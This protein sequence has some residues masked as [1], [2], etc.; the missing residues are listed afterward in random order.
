MV[1]LGVFATAAS[2]L[3]RG[4][5]LILSAFLVASTLTLTINGTDAAEA[6]Q[7]EQG[8]GQ[9][10][11]AVVSDLTRW[12]IQK[13]RWTISTTPSIRLGSNE[14][15]ITL[16]FGS[17]FEPNG[18]EMHSLY[19]RK[20][21]VI[22]LRNTWKS[23][24]IVDRSLLLHELVHHLQLLNGMKVACPEEYEAQAYHLQIEWLREQ[25]VNEPYKLLGL[26]KF[27]IDGLSQCQ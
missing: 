17:G 24:T 22:Y 25:S 4:L 8:Q 13:T 5:T 20:S 12:I 14:Q 19:S 23:A 1:A 26:T 7:T 3:T 27:D 16:Y 15:L 21:H 10:D 6:Q 18:I 2:R 9:I 11:P